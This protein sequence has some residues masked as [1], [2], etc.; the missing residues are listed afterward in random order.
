ML[1]VPGL[2]IQESPLGGRGVFSSMDIP[3][4]SI[5]EVCPVLVIPK[6]ELPIIH[7]T[8]LHDYYFT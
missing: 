7:K 6:S 4:D 3:K 8:I 2:F 1:Q 5:I